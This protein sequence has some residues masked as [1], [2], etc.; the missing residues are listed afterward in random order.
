MNLHAKAILSVL[1]FSLKTAGLDEKWI[2][3]VL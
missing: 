2:A 1:Y 3:D